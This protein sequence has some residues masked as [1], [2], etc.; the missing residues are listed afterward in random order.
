MVNFIDRLSE[1]PESPINQACNG[2]SEAKAA[3]RFFQNENVC[4]AD[5]LA[6]H[7]SQVV[8]RA[9]KMG[10]FWRFK[11]QVIFL[12]PAIRRRRDQ[13]LFQNPLERTSK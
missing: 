2:W 12:I 8:E 11:I 1:S 13:G 6:S 7:L 3:F 5:I 10:R 9:K 4:E